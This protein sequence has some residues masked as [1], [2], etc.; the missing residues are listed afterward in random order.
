VAAASGPAEGSYAG[1]RGLAAGHD[2]E[3]RGPGV[4]ARRWRDGGVAEQEATGR[5]G[6]GRGP[7][8]M[9][10]R[11][12]G[13]VTARCEARWA[14]GSVRRG[15]EW[16]RAPGPHVGARSYFLRPRKDITCQSN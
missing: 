9:A 11:R 1:R 6:E 14:D 16:R 13:G 15:S 4:V 12:C 10:A 7:G 2:R 5:D 3:E 8:G